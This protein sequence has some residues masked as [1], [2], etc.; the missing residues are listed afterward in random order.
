MMLLAMLAP[1]VWWWTGIPAFQAAAPDFFAQFGPRLVAEAAAMA[2]VSRWSVMP[3]LSGIAPL[4]VAPAAMAAAARALL[5]PRGHRFA[6]TLKGGDRQRVVVHGRL[7]GWLVGLMVTIML[8]MALHFREGPSGQWVNVA[9]SGYALAILFLGLLVAVELPR[10]RRQERVWLDEAVAVDGRPARLL[11]LSVTGACV[12]GEAAMDEVMLDIMDVG[13]VPGR[14]LRREGGRLHVEFH[15]AE[16][17]RDLLIRKLYTGA[18]ILA[19][20]ECDPGRAMRAAARR[21]F[22]SSV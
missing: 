3:V 19:H 18:A 22:V 20:A 8:G 9:W 4:V 5:R 21:G 11:D 2:W 13:R 10:R 1:V 14:V 12:A 15:D 16:A 17:W 6:V 7:L